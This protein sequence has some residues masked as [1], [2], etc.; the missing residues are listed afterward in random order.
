MSNGCGSQN[1]KEAE[2]MVAQQ[3]VHQAQ[4]HQWEGCSQVEFPS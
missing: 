3:E 2:L 4:L 1:P